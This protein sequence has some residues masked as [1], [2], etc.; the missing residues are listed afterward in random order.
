M[1][2]TDDRLVPAYHQLLLRVAG[3]A[4]DDTVSAARGLL[5]EGRIAETAG[6]ILATVLADRVPIRP[7]DA[8]LLVQTLPDVPAVVQLASAVPATDERARPAYD[9]APVLMSPSTAPPPLVLDLTAPGSDLDAADEAAVAALGQLPDAVALWRV[10]RSPH[11]DR[12]DAGPVRVYLLET[13]ADAAQLPGATAWLQ[14]TLVAAG[15]S[16]PQVETYGPGVTL[17]AYQQAA[18]GQAALLWAA[19]APRPV[20]IARVFDSYHPAL[21]GQFAADHPT[22]SA[23]DEAARVLAYLDA[24]EV[25][26]ATT[27]REGDVFDQ[28][29]GLVVPM[30]FRTDGTW[31]WTDTVA[32]YL[33]TYAL[34]P[35][36]EL[37]AHIR[38]LDHRFPAVDAVRAHR[39]M[40]ALTSPAPA[41]E[42][43][44]GRG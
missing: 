18:R 27:A 4:P 13:A 9:F 14:Q 17:P 41:A 21:G 3:W 35:D 23:G 36:A 40:V 19:E 44:A 10:W 6:A 15:V 42:A 26:L 16:D 43:P 24:G 25:L 5:A 8:E 32:Y 1:T 11:A 29:A 33:R 30:S 28:E 2:T 39:A 34:S 37:L 7:D 31:I 12:T 20:P 38:A 22:L